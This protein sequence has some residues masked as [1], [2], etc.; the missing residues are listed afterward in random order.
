MRS[1]VHGAERG[2]QVV[3]DSAWL[4][5]SEDCL[6]RVF[7][8]PAASIF[9]VMHDEHAMQ[10]GRGLFWSAPLQRKSVSLL[11]LRRALRWPAVWGQQRLS[12][13]RSL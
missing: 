4:Q 3:R 11:P 10:R 8:F 2:V 1:G 7:G 12:D 13:R 6:P 5:R 9:T